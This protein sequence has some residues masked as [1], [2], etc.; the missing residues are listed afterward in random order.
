MVI[1]KVDIFRACGFVIMFFI[2][3]TYFDLGLPGSFLGGALV[4]QVCGNVGTFFD[5]R[6]KRTA[7]D[8]DGAPSDD[9]LRRP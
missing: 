9:E 2:L 5:N 7:S 6:E 1:K 4:G 3:F 8:Q